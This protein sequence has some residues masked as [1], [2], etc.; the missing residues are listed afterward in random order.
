LNVLG[1]EAFLVRFGFW[2]CLLFARD[3][4]VAFE[5]AAVDFVTT[6][7]SSDSGASSIYLA[8]DFLPFPTGDLLLPALVLGGI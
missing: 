1:L 3:E 4:L 2:S 7:S 6:L 8:A 5:K